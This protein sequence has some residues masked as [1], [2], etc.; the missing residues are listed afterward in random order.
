MLLLV[1]L[2]LTVPLLVPERRVLVGVPVRG[3]TCAPC[4]S[5]CWGLLQALP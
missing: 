2:L 3:N 5:C 1:L 4:C